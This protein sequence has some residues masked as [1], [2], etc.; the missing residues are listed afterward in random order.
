MR[1]CLGIDQLSVD[2]NLIGRPPDA[3]FEHVAHTKL[4][5]DLLRVDRLVPIGER[6]VARNHQRLLD[7]RQIRRQILSYSIGEILLLR[8]TAQVGERQDDNRQA[9]R[10]DSYWM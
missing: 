6:S 10:S 9:W 4:A 7:P 8:I 1:V 5:T 3:A 2:P